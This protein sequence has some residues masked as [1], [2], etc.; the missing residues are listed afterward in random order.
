MKRHD[1]PKGTI[2]LAL[3]LAE[4]GTSILQKWRMYSGAE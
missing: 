4:L 3:K 2:I 1:S